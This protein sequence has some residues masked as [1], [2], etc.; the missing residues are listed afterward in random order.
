M[1]YCLKWNNR[2]YHLKDA[3]EISIKYIED[4]GLLDFL[5]KYAD[6]RIILRI[7][8]KDFIDS[9]LAKLV[10]IKRQFPDYQ[11]TVALDEYHPQL[12]EKMKEKELP[13]YIA[14]PVKNWE[15]LNHYVKD[16][17]VSD[18]D[19][20]GALGFELLKVKRFLEKF[21]P[22][23]K[24]RITPNIITSDSLH[25]PPLQMFFVRPDDLDQYEPYVDVVEFEGLEHQD[26]F[27]NIYAKEKTF[28]GKLNQV[29][30]N[31]P[32]S[33]DNLGLIPSFGERRIGCG[34]ECLYGGKC[35]RCNNLADL[36]QE[37]GTRA[38]TKIIEN[39]K[40]KIEKN[41]LN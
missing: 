26:T 32:L 37:M 38:R 2:C 12:I 25:C 9:E 4:K 21:G 17:K 8:A 40:E 23:T 16:L 11:F 13:F 3:D 34:R 10:A 31:F 28:V 33:I 6:K 15:V 22:N 7:I 39:I 27:F 20:S 29:I 24:V 14:Q 18:I 41:E 1:K 19:L 36:S 35:R 5:E 30:Y